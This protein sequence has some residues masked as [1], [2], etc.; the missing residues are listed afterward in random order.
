MKNCI[1]LKHLTMREMEEFVK[2]AGGKSY[3]AGQ[4]AKWIFERGVSDFVLM[5]DLGKD[6]RARLSA[7]SRITGLRLV[8]RQASSD[9]TVKF[10]YR[11]E[12]GLTVESVWI[13]GGKRRTLCV[14][15]QAGCRLNC[16]FCLTGKNGFRRNL[17]AAEIVD[18]VIQS[19]AGAP[20]GRITNVVLMGMGEPLD[21]YENTLRALKVMTEPDFHLIGARRITLSTAG[22][23]PGIRRLAG[24]FPGV[25]LAVSLNSC[26]NAV[27]SRI[28]PVNKKYPLE[29]LRKALGAFPLPKGKRITLEYVLLSGVNDSIEDAQKLVRFVAGL[30]AKINLI[31]F[32]QCAQLPY[33]SPSSQTVK[34][35]REYL[36]GRG[37]PVFIRASRGADIMAACGQLDGEGLS[38]QSIQL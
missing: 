25:K 7:I 16:G 4:I 5:T 26:D 2:S 36:T 14:S 3:R 1:D 13:P 32:N 33:K 20:D 21:N 10:L 29:E 28:M 17:C 22:V 11:L 31:P 27:R 8:A 37:L 9:G 23:V 30:K 18:Q 34:R 6:L 38:S 15:T 24:D 12:D 35:F 19:R